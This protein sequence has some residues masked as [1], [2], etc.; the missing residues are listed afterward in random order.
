MERNSLY[1]MACKMTSIPCTAYF[2]QS[3]RHRML[4]HCECLKRIL[5]WRHSKLKK[6]RILNL[7]S[8]MVQNEVQKP[9]WI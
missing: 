3:R 4:Y 5:M 1:S 2:N 9:E 6:A 8:A 7:R